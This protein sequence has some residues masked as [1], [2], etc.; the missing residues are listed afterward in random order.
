[1]KDDEG[2]PLPGVAVEASSPAAMGMLTAITSD[3]GSYRF[4]NLAPGIYKLTFTLD[5]FQSVERENIKVALNRS[6]TLNVT[7]KPSI[8]EEEVTVIAE[9]PII[10][11]KMSGLS[12]NFT[13]QDI[14]NLPA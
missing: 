2:V 7:M 3:K 11:V 14:E 8:L 6:M 13:S 1:M 10:D 5:S 9:T 12:S 4:G